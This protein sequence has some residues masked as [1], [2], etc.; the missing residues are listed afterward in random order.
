MSNIKKEIVNELHKP[1]RKYFKRRRVI[2]KGIND[3]FQADL[4]EMIP[5]AKVN[6]GHKYILVVINVFS[7]FV[8]CE[9][10][11]TKSG[12]NV[13][14]AMKKIL[15]DVK[16]PPKNLQ[17]DMG[18]EFYNKEF[19]KLMDEMKINHYSSY[20]SLKASVVERV[21]RT[22]KNKMWKLF[23]L[24]GNYKWLNFLSD[25][26]A[27]YNN[28]KHRTIG[29]K[30]KNV[31]KKDEKHL[32]RTVYNHLKIVD[33]RKRK[34]KANDYVRISKYRQAFS[35]GYTPNWS[36]EIFKIRKVH[37]SN[38]RTYLLEDQAGEQILGGFYDHE[39]QKV[40]YPDIY[41]V[42][43]VLRKKNNKLYVKWLGLSNEHNSWISNNN[44]V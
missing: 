43:K 20:T 6:K 32:L 30:P 10:V 41:L 12:K 27:E 37:K 44:I 1:V 8:W 21:N 15:S 11:K 18:K 25:I 13:T 34:F 5:Y 35:K 39:M 33:P 26:V 14:E 28:T 29:M 3:L 36:N 19:K 24:H 7:K 17:T 38:P 22:L 40:K 42:E 4:V 16:V 23:S 31:K 9:P 2:V